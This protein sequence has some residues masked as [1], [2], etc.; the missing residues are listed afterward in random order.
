MNVPKKSLPQLKEDWHAADSAGDIEERGRIGRELAT[1]FPDNPTCLRRLK[2]DHVDDP[3]V[4][5]GI[6]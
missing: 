1:R 4:G 3:S 5:G 2:V 6:E